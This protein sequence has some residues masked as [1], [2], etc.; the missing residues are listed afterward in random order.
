MTNRRE[1][2]RSPNAPWMTLEQPLLHV[3]DLTVSYRSPGGRQLVALE[4]LTF[5]I[6]E[7]ETVGLLGESGSGKTTL[8]LALL[9]LL[10][11]AGGVLRGSVV[12]R[13][14][15]L[16]RLG[17]RELQRL[18]GASISMVY[19]EPGA[20]LNPVL[21][22]GEQ[23]SEVIRAH[24]CLSRDQLREEA[25]CLLRQVGLPEE[26]RVR[27]A[28]PHQLS[29]G[30]LQRV[31]IAQAIACHP[32]LLIADE[33]TTAL[34]RATQLGILDLLSDLREKLHIALLLITHDR[35]V[36]MR[37]VG[38][39][40]VLRDGRI[41]EQGPT[42]EVVRKSS[43][44][45]TRTLL[46]S[47]E[48]TGRPKNHGLSLAPR[49]DK[50]PG[51][52]SCR[53]P[54][55]FDQ[56]RVGDRTNFLEADD[57]RNTGPDGIDSE[58][59]KRETLLFAL[60]L[61]KRY[62]QGRWLSAGRYRVEA[63]HGVELRLRA[64]STLALIGASGSG[65]STVARC[66]ACLERPDSGEIW[67]KGTNLVAL[68]HR[69]LVPFRRQ[70]QMIFQD[71]GSSLNP[72]FTAAEI[73]SEP[74][75][76]VGRGTKQECRDLAL[77][78]MKRVGLSPDSAA[79]LPHQFSAGQRRR[80]AIA[81]AL[82]VEPTLLI[83]DEA[84]AGLDRPIQAQIAD[85]LLELQATLSLTYLY[86]SHDLDLVARFADRVAV[87]HQGQIVETVNASDL[88]ATPHSAPAS[89]LVNATFKLASLRSELA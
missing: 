42:A 46:N 5:D 70:I 50:T 6:A 65:K 38:R 17:E 2:A 40:I 81:R 63:L 39:I 13:G 28:Y 43:D 54:S 88:L 8:G 69:D 68:R 15:N 9:G 62:V 31:A 48:L 53:V 56:P 22:V 80:L 83:L 24:R 41:V 64:G 10:P 16:L 79:R 14:E 60:N 47:P 32:R 34:D 37:A 26:T 52:T 84:L 35:S 20:A 67:F 55:S 19:Q 7:G 72:R 23:V 30:Q 75:L 3:D 25:A 82:S 76:A 18:R 45:Y 29:G 89:T 87:I 4:S 1:V 61:Q 57:I 77:G 12:W 11:R 21:R 73:I 58:R 33:P 85:L 44:T 78:L 71:P 49:T 51:P 86:I 66:L 59:G 36:L 27:E 74:L